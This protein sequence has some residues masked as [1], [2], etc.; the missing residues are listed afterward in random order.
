MNP[1][2]F[3]V[4]AVKNSAYQFGLAGL[5]ALVKAGE[6]GKKAFDTFVK[7]GEEAVNL[8]EAT[9]KQQSKMTESALGNVKNMATDSWEKM[10]Q[11]FD[12]RVSDALGRLGIPNRGDYEDLAK[13]IEKLATLIEE[14]TEVLEKAEQQEPK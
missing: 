6:E 5:G 2:L 13:R 12:N 8:T 11:I 9:V 1:N 7:A 4:N 3:F 14:Q 10:E